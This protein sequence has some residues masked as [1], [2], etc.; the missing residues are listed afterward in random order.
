MTNKDLS[1]K[2]RLKEALELSDQ[3]YVEKYPR[4]ENEIQYSAGYL[5]K[6]RQ[7]KKRS[8]NPFYQYGKTFVKS[9]AGL[10]AAMLIIFG[11]SVMVDT[12]K[13]S[14]IGFF[15]SISSAISENPVFKDP[16][17]HGAQ[18]TDAMVEP[19]EHEFTV[20]YQTDAQKHYYF[21]SKSGCKEEFSEFHKYIHKPGTYHLECEVCGRRPK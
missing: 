12:V 21:C 5:K 14:V 3:R 8:K 19:H 11:C 13:G 15:D 17:H 6:I 20:L 2:A 10:A 9:V 1:G 7:L 4:A 16:N 18:D